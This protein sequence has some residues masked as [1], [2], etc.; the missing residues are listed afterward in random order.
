MTRDI[1]I[2]GDNLTGLVTAYRLL[3]YGYH[4]RIVDTQ[5]RIQPTIHLGTLGE[6]TKPASLS[7]TPALTE[8]WQIPLILHGFYHSTWALLQELS[9]E[10]PPQTSQPVCL[11]FAAEGR[12]PIALPRISRLKWLHSLTR[13]TFFKGLSWAD[14]WHVINFLE[15]QWEDNLLPNPKP[16]IE[17]VEAWLI[18]AKQSEYSRSHF[19]NPLCRLFLNCDL[20]QASLSS[21]IEALS[22]YWLGQPTDAATFLAP[23]ETL[24]KLEAEIRQRLMNKGVRFHTSKAR[25]H[26][27]TDS[28]EIQSIELDEKPFKAQAYISALPPRS[29]L[30]LLPE[31]ALARY[32]YFTSLAQIP[33]VWG[34][35]VRFTLSNSLVPPRLI[36]NLDPFDWITAQPSENSDSPKTMVTCVTFRESIALKH[37]DEWLLQTAWTFI[38]KL[39]NLSHTQE[40]CEPHIIR[41]VGPFFPCHRGCRSHRPISKTPLSNLFLAGP[42]VATTLPSSLE[43]TIKSANACAEAVATACYGSGK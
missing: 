21:F 12:K 29:L 1:L 4:I 33:E 34:L 2:L 23:P 17:S 31:R 24:N 37:N 15:K 32:A 22:Q 16:D 39:F 43:S 41:Q 30:P 11:E 38:Q 10:W 28:E 36:L 8:S 26:S 27:H 5:C 6:S 42:W 20:S 19:W 13:F 35:A 7:P 3:H 14:R 9:F 18:S 40:F 25:I